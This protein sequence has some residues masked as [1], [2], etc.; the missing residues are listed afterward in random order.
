MTAASASAFER[1]YFDT[2][3]IDYER[4]NPSWKLRFYRRLLTSY[5]APS[6]RRTLLE[7]GC[8]LGSFLASLDTSWDKY[9]FDV[10]RYAVGH[11]R[12]KVPNAHLVVASG[13]RIPFARRFDAIVSF[14]VLEHLAAPEDAFDE[15]ASRLEPSGIFVFVVPVYDGLSGPVIRRLDHDVT[16]LQKHGRGFWLDLVSR[17]F[18]VVAWHGLVRYLLPGGVYLNWPTRLGR[19]HAPAIAVVARLN[20]AVS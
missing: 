1:E 9:G 19:R 18:R 10:S 7:I 8:G 17:R 4:Q 13:A 15:V 2:A 14:D 5:L 11:A 12:A 3:Y 6:P 20:G 16:H